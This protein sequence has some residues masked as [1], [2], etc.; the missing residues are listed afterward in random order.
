[1]FYVFY[2]QYLTIVEDTIQNLSICIAAI[3]VVTFVLLGFDIISAFMVVLTITMIV[4]DI[5]GFMAL[6]DISINA[7]TLVN[8][9]MVSQPPYSFPYSTELYKLFFQKSRESESFINQILNFYE[10]YFFANIND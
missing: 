6:W 9:V 5:L 2:E 4:I 7:V 8:L 10:K 1:M 3:F